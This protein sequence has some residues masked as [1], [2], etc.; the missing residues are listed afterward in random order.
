MGL[1]G[2]GGGVPHA[3]AVG[4]TSLGLVIEGLTLLTTAVGNRVPA[5]HGVKLAG[6]RGGAS[7]AV[8]LAGSYA[9]LHLPDALGISVAL[10][11]VGEAVGALL[12]ASVVAPHASGGSVASG[13]AAELVAVTVA[14]S[15]LPIPLALGV[16]ITSGLGGVLEDATDHAVANTVG[17]HLIISAR[18]VEGEQITVHAAGSW[19]AI[20]HA[21]VIGLAA[22][23][24]IVH[25]LALLP[26][27]VTHAPVPET[28]VIACAH[29]LEGEGSALTTALVLLELAVGVSEALTLIGELNAVTA[30]LE[31]LGIPHAL[32]VT[33]AG[34][35]AHVLAVRAALVA[36]EVITGLEATV[37]LNLAEGRLV[38]QHASKCALASGG[39][40]HAGGVG[41]AVSLVAVLDLASLLA[42][43]HGGGA[44]LPL[45]KLVV[46]ASDAGLGCIE[47]ELF[48]VVA[49]LL[50]GN[51]GVI[52]L[53]VVGEVAG[54]GAGVSEEL[55][56]AA[57]AAITLN[58]TGGCPLAGGEVGA[59]VALYN[60]GAVLG[61]L[62]TGSIPPTPGVG[63]A[64]TGVVVAVEASTL[65]EA[66]VALDGTHRL[67]E[68][69]AV[70]SGL[71]HL[72]EL[73]WVVAGARL[74]TGS[75]SLVVHTVEVG[76]AR[77]SR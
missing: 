12:A 20:P 66:V 64:G 42:L 21:A 57:E 48:V 65:A 35:L 4:V 40:P 70:N 61:T 45:A 38:D 34:T 67:G 60:T 47:V 19:S 8:T 74:N 68:A 11:S 72:G 23:K 54:V 62:V 69:S 33:V 44:D 52:P 36:G 31:L 32:G 39:V 6:G 71:G 3:L 15:A 77:G 51:G 7:I 63:V 27:S 75:D 25:K 16:S 1:A 17:A 13:N 5:T 9:S 73:L 37:V 58:G 14:V 29:V 76:V 22:L 55:I 10:V 49:L 41:A 18:G 46:I 28:V 59:L 26:A 24:V 2:A 30:A 43:G 56:L 50:A 53:A